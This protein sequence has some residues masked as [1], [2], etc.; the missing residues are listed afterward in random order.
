MRSHQI[1][2]Q[3]GYAAGSVNDLYGRLVGRH[4]ADHIP[5]K[6]RIIPVNMPGATSLV[7]ANSLANVAPKDGSVIGIVFDRVAL[8]P[9]LGTANAQFDGRSFNWLGSVLKT[10]RGLHDLAHRAGQDDRGCASL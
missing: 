9:L 7:L 2:L 5:G 6:P 8:E 4:L 10:T 3:I 1:R